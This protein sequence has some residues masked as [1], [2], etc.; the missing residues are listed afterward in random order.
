MQYYLVLVLFNTFPYQPLCF[1]VLMLHFSSGAEG[2][3][4]STHY[5]TRHPA[6]SSLM[7]I[8][9]AFLQWGGW[10]LLMSCWGGGGGFYSVK[11]KGPDF[12]LP[13]RARRLR[14]PRLDAEAA[15]ASP[16]R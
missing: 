11:K 16:A 1:T 4:R 2:D 3:S 7:Y 5:T 10:I 15:R 6:C 8:Y 14:N 9:E 12:S 13:E